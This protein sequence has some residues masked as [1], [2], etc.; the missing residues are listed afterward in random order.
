MNIKAIIATLVLGSSSV[1][2]A[3]PGVRDHRGIDENCETPVAS[4]PV[5]NQP[6]YGQPAYGQ[7]VYNQPAYGQ[8]VYGQPVYGQPVAQPVYAQP[9]Q[10]IYQPG[11]QPGWQP[12]AVT[13]ASGLGF[14]NF[15]RT[16]ITVGRQAGQFDALQITGTGGRS[17]IKLINI[18]FADGTHQTVRNVNQTL[19]GNQSMT[20]DLAG[21]HRAIR[22]ITIYGGDTANGWRRG[23]SSFSVTAL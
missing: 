13:L 6:A 8:P 15:D 7:P 14:G 19:V 9:A 12:R 16:A 4:Q 11:W 20:I 1:A 5:Y 10:P 3:A 23:G 17:T 18:V 2:L 22:D 21:D